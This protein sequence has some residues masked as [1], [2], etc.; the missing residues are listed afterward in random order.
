MAAVLASGE[1]AAVSHQAA[2]VL[3]HFLQ[4]ALGPVDITVPSW[5]RPRDGIALHV[6]S[7]AETTIRLGIRT[8][9]AER[10]LLDL[11]ATDIEERPLRR[12]LHEAEV[13]RATTHQKTLSFLASHAGTPGAPRLRRLLD[14]G[15]APTR[16]ELEDRLH[17]LIHDLHPE[18]NARIEGYEVDFLFR[19]ERVVVEADGTRFHATP[20][21]RKR[22]ARKQAHLEAHGLRVLRAGYDDVTQRPAET[23]AR[24]LRALT[25]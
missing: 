12:A 10:T 20:E 19:A 7:T 4:Q 24:V 17:A 11:A 23:R 25:P 9:T 1:L 14:L 5:R 8:T 16:S 13:Q 21:A 18:C 15:P 3:H 6:A 2:G 22:D